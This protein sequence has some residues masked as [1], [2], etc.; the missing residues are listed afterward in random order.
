MKEPIETMQPVAFNPS[1]TFTPQQQKPLAASASYNPFM[2]APTKSFKPTDQKSKMVE[3]F[4]NIAEKADEANRFKTEMCKNWSET[5][6][7]RYNKKCQFAH[8]EHEL[9]EPAKRV[10]ESRYKKKKCRAFHLTNSCMYGSRCIYNHEYRKF[11]R[12]QKRY[13]TPQF[14]VLE[15]LFQSAQS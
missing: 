9:S 2:K 7:C 15:T 14:Y 8:G 1:A 6:F 13:Y 4:L 3:K 11:E 5:G 10:H 12:L